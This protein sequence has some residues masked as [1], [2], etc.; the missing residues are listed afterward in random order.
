MEEWI[1]WLQANW[2]TA[3]Q[4]VGIL[5]SLWLAVATLRRDIQTRRTADLLS[6]TAHH[7]ELWKD[8]YRSP[9]LQRIFQTEV[10][11]VG[12][13]ISVAEE[14]FLN[15]AIVHFY[16]GWR[17]VVAQ[18]IVPPRVFASDVRSFFSLPLPHAVWERTK[19]VRDPNFVRFVDKAQRQ[20]SA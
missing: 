17:L 14:E 5:G 6:L 19:A 20:A 16:V 11:L 18:R 15:S 2:F 12:L 13:P 1:P 9:E 10:D 3:I 4:T 8:S 7:R